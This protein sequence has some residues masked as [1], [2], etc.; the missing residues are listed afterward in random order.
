MT[1]ARDSLTIYAKQGMGKDPSPPG[2]MRDLLKDR[3]LCRWLVAH[4]PKDFRPTCLPR[5]PP[6]RALTRTSEWL[7]LPPVSDLSAKLSASAVQ[8]YET[9]PLQFKLEREW[10]NPGEVPAAMQYG[11]VIHRVLL[12][13]YN[14]VRAE[15][16]MEDEAVIQLFR[17]ELPPLPSRTATSMISIRIKASSNC[18]NFWLLPPRSRRPKYSTLEEFFDVKWAT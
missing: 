17:D 4:G 18:R 1:R 14:S 11:G 8:T 6:C 9:C 3:S 10:K 7:N 15:R 13:F 12:E 16:Q 5:R 2:F